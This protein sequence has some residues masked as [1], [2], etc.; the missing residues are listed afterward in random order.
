MFLEKFMNENS[1]W[2][3]KL[4]V[5]PYCIETK[6][7]GDYNILKYNMIMSDFNL[8]E[9]IEARGSIFR[10]DENGIWIC[11]CRALDKFG[12][13]GES[14]AATPR[15]G[16]DKGVDVQE[17]IDGSIVKVWYDRNRW[18]ISTNGT[19]DA[20]KADCGDTTFGNLFIKIL[21]VEPDFF[22]LYLNPECCYF[23]ELVCPQYNHIVIRY[24]E[25]AIYY[26]GCRNLKTGYEVLPENSYMK[27][28]NVKYPRHFTYHSLAECVEAAHRMGVDEEGYVCVSK[29]MENGSYL[30]IKVKGDE[31]LRLHRIRGNGALTVLRV[32]EMWQS[33]S[34]D[35]FIAYYPE[36][37]EFVNSVANSIKNLV[38]IADLAFSTINSYRDIGNRADFARYANTY[39]QPLR[40]YLFARLDNKTANAAEFYK[41]MRARNLAA[42]IQTTVSNKEVGVADDE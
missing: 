16:W 38:S 31:Y 26:L 27:F 6:E 40:A 36:F 1:D 20:F 7:D 2:Q 42:H 34:L 28:T 29:N 32:V 12:N 8:P 22:S 10:K 4:A 37:N 14:Y 35:D 30:R 21:G 19:I 9:V 23:F 33:N 3:A 39:I 5:E 17:K 41:N 24:K 13:Y 25:N 15:M 11:F 18:H